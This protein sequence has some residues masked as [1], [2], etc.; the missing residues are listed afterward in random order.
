M[1]H[2]F[3]ESLIPEE[4][5]A[6]DADKDTKD[7]DEEDDNDEPELPVERVEEREMTDAHTDTDHVDPGSVDGDTAV[8]P[9]HADTGV[10]AGERRDQ[11]V[12]G[13]GPLSDGDRGVVG[14]GAGQHHCVIDHPAHSW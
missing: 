4:Y 13:P 2:A 14:G 8:L 11:G 10:E 3:K 6:N 1:Y 9:R 7:A 5:F 12:P